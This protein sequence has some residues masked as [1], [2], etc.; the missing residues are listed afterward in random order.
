MAQQQR[1]DQLV[2]L[3]MHADDVLNVFVRGDDHQLHQAARIATHNGVEPAAMSAVMADLSD[4]FGWRH[5]VAA[6]MGVPQPAQLP[7][8]DSRAEL[9]QARTAAAVRASNH[10]AGKG[11]GKGSRRHHTRHALTMEQIIEFIHQHPEGCRAKDIAEALMPGHK[12]NRHTVS[13]RL[14]AY[15]GKLARTGEPSAITE[16]A[17]A[18]GYLTFYPRST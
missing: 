15:R 4:V 7:E 10:P 18:R 9:P 16:V 8:R 17:D 6:P 13:N 12:E 14:V 5:V 1:P 3:G 2:V 11:K